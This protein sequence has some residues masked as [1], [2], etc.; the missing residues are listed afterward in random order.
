MDTRED[1]RVTRS[2]AAIIAAAERIFLADGYQGATLEKV[3]AASGLAKR[4]IYNLYADKE[5]LFRATI[6]SAITVADG[7]AASLASELRESHGVAD[8]PGIAQSLAQATI[9]GPALRL[10]RLLVMESRQFPDLVREYR[11][12]APERVMS[13]LAD[14]FAEL[15]RRGELRLDDPH[16]AAEHFAFLVMGADLDRGMFDGRVPS[17]RHVR[18]R[19][20]AG[21]GAFLRAYGTD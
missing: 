1:P 17:R 4:T 13:A 12:R 18:A 10:R 3:A 15:A 16:L 6:L 11:D 20:R 9:L 2:R 5:D 19:A 8:V 14:L 21:A 7:F